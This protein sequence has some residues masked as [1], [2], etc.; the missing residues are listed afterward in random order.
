MNIGKRFQLFRRRKHLT[1]KE[2]AE[3]IGVKSYQLANY[4][5]NRSEPSLKTL[6]NMART[7]QVTTDQL[8]GNTRRP[9]PLPSEE[10]LD[11]EEAAKAELERILKKFLK[12]YG[13]AN[14]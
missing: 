4:E 1:Q 10:S 13:S 2:A 12:D 5:S 9:F 14:K 3:Q 11:E 8:L 6:V 7:Y